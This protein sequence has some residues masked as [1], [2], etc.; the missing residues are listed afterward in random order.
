[1][2]Y[3]STRNRE[4]EPVPL[5]YHEVIHQGLAADG[6]LFVTEM[7]KLGTQRLLEMSS[8]NYED[9]VD[10]VLWLLGSHSNIDLTYGAYSYDNFPNRS[11]RSAA[12]LKRIKENLYIQDLS[13]GPTFAFKDLALQLLTRQINDDLVSN[14]SAL[15]L[16]I[17]TSGDTGSAAGA[18]VLGRSAMAA[19][20]L[21]PET[22]P[23]E[24]QQAQMKEQSFDGSNVHQIHMPFDFDTCQDIVKALKK[25]PEFENLG[26]LNS[27]NWG[28]I[29]AQIA[30]Y[31]AGYFEAVRD[32]GKIGDPVDFVVPTGNFGNVLAGYYARKMGLPIRHLV[33]ATNEN[34]VLRVLINLGIYKIPE[35]AKVTTSPSMDI[36]VSSNFERL[37]YELFE[38]DGNRT[39]NYMDNVRKNSTVNFTDYGLASDALIKLGFRAHTS[40]ATD[41]LW[42][43]KTAYK[44]FEGCLIDPHTADGM[45]AAMRHFEEVG[46]EVKTV[47]LATAD[48]VKFEDTMCQALGFTPERDDPRTIGLEVRASKTG[49]FIRLAS[50]DEVITYIR[51][52]RLNK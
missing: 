41:R 20:I 30:Y 31:F 5:S 3:T 40:R 18:G 24:F 26:A 19:F 45:W 25:M 35:E 13:D 37:V 17:A 8:F 21:S 39:A 48:P 27:I 14:G 10:E 16:V 6:G 4:Q 33:V 43:I 52:N 38:Q 23:T 9:V 32:N 12:P 36:T 15:D 50:I 7:P 51:E 29:A 11:P 44:E 34:D 49:R 2:L 46:H 28:R 47:V 42:T 22:G 1:M